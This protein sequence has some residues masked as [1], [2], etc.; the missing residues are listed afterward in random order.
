MAGK[1]AVVDFICPLKK[2]DNFLSP[3]TQ[4]GWTQLDRQVR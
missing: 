2:Q 3:I 1:V 4:C